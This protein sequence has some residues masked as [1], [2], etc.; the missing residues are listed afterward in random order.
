MLAAAFLPAFNQ[1]TGKQLTLPFG[2]PVF[3]FALAGLLLMVGFVAGSYPALYL[4]SLNPIRVLKG[5]LKFTWRSIFFR[6]GLVV[7]QFTLSVLLI[8][9]MIVIYRQLN[10]IQKKNIGYDRENLIYIPL[11]GDLAKNYEL[12]KEEIAQTPDILSATKIRQSPTSM[13][14]HTG[15][16]SWTGK[17]PNVLVSFVN[18]VVGYDLVKTMNLTLMSGRDFSRDFRTDSVSFLV[19]ETALERIGYKDP[20]GKP[21]WWG[22]REGKIIGIIRDFHFT[23]LHDKIEPLIV[24]LD[25]QRP[26]GTVLVRTKAGKTKEALTHLETICKTLNPKFPFSYQFSDL[27]FARLYH[28]EQIVGQLARYFAFLAIFISCLGLFGLATFTAE[29]RTKEIGVRKVLG[30]RV[31]NIASMLSKDLLKPVLI[32]VVIAT[33]L[34]YFFMRHWLQDFAYRTDM[35]WWIFLLAGLAAVMISLITVGYQAI[36]A[37]IAAPASSLRAE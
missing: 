18:T 31:M 21:L 3:W 15:D 24:R 30:A 27:E 35:S 29:Q 16:I 12:F 37:A 28:S 36:R 6:K 22:K 11:E 14:N 32:A 26:W 7:F 1:L 2:N 8:V 33:P 4:S 25:E 20:I 10:Y 5:R 9:G 23:S 13:G 19:N 17:D 34:A